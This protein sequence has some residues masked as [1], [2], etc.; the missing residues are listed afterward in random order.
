[1]T[2]FIESINGRGVRNTAAA[3]VGG[4]IGSIDALRGFD[5]F[6]IMGGGIMVEGL[7]KIWD[8]SLTRFLGA[9]MR[10]VDWLGFHFFDIIMPLFMFLA[11]MSVYLSLRKRIAG[12]GKD[13]TIWLHT[14]RRAIVLWLLGMVIQGNLL[15]LDVH[16]MA[17][18]SNTLQAIAAGYLIATVFVLYLRVVW[19]IIA[20]A[21]LLA[22][23]WA[24]MTY[25]PVADEVARFSIDGNVAM[26]IDMSVLGSMRDGTQYAWL[27][28]SVNFGATTMLGVW[29]AMII[30]S[31][32]SQLKRVGRLAATGA[33]LVATGL[34]WG[35]WSPIIKALWTSSFVLFS[36][37]LCFLLMSLW[38]LMID[39]WQ[40]KGVLVKGMTVLGSNA[41]F[42]YVVWN[43]FEWDLMSAGH[44]VVG[45]V[46]RLLP[47][48]EGVLVPLTAFAM[49][50]I[51]MRYMYGNK[52]FIKI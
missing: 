13:S 26:A 14:I 19:Q 37:G 36:G 2:S 43:L 15:G 48:W 29:C 47:S 41:I 33:V 40:W 9:Q 34:I 22:A 45:G 39:V 38:S 49:I 24:I 17:L 32:C 7:D 11:G 23:Y 3:T 27:L 20:T 50:Y 25:I 1:M 10:H 12:G 8:C 16:N 18:Y 44:R 6:W 30:T 31:S 5:M 4:R 21:L 42:G 28:P 35:V 51:L 46:V 52:T